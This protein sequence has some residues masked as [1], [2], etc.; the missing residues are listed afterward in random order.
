MNYTKI[1]HE[2]DLATATIVF[3]NEI[4]GMLSEKSLMIDTAVDMLRKCRQS[5][6]IFD[7]YKDLNFE[8]KR[9]FKKVI[10]TTM[11]KYIRDNFQDYVTTDDNDDTDMTMLDTISGSRSL[12]PENI[13]A[14]KDLLSDIREI[15][16]DYTARQKKIICMYL[17]RRS[18]REIARFFNIP[19]MTVHDLV[20]KF[21]AAV[22][23]R[24]E[25]TD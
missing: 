9:Y 10:L 12:E 19:T 16:K 23:K 11:F 22:S 17:N 20:T 5:K 8:N 1:I 21:R 13:L 6:G 3:E 14:Y 15:A 18:F 4:S 2:N 7:L 24:I 25:P